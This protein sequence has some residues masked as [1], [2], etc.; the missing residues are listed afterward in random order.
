MHS[1]SKA[2]ASEQVYTSHEKGCL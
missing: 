2:M 1:I